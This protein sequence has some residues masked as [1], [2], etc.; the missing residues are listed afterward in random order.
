MRMIG[1][2]VI[3][4]NTAYPYADVSYLQ[5]EKQLIHMYMYVRIKQRNKTLLL[6]EINANMLH[7]FR[8]NKFTIS[9]FLISCFYSVFK[10]LYLEL[11]IR[12]WTDDMYDKFAGVSSHQRSVHSLFVRST[13]VH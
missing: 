12:W 2:N 3:K 5:W 1:M 8:I 10:G 11:L 9:Y 6:G 7:S 4:N 13:L